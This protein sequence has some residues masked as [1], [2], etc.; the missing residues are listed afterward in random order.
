MTWNLTADSRPPALSGSGLRAGAWPA[1]AVAQLRADGFIADANESV[2][3]TRQL[4]HI[5]SEILRAQYPDVIYSQIVDTRVN[6]LDPTDEVYTW[7]E[8]DGTSRWQEKGTHR[9]NDLEAASIHR[10][11][12]SVRFFSF[13][14]EYGYDFHD[15]RKAS[16]LGINLDG[17]Y[18]ALVRGGWE[19]LYEQIVAEGYGSTPMKGILNQ[20][21]VNVETEGAALHTLA[22]GA[23][24]TR[25]KAIV[26]AKIVA[27]KSIS[28]LMPNRL[29]VYPDLYEAMVNKHM[30][31]STH[32]NTR[33][34]MQ[35][36]MAYLASRGMS[37]F[38]VIP[39]RYTEAAGDSGKH[40]LVLYR[41][42][43]EIVQGLVSVP[44]EQL[45]PFRTKWGWEVPCHGRTA[46][47]VVKQKAG[48][49]YIDSPTA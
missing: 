17:E 42:S 2:I 34:V 33:S 20:A 38:Q 19:R 4:E 36:F 47:V 39:W 49:E 3:F 29:L 10:G 9:Q 37:D 41:K 7:R 25:L 14:S 32:I 48:V 44:F 46:G 16:R 11:E 24:L 26:S 6:G 8:Q 27:Q 23:L 45:P 12:N 21:G 30:D 43:P 35:E 15:L 18:G 31:T 1:M 28:G 5:E 22:A 40:R 13:V